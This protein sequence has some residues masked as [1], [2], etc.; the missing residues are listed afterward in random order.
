MYPYSE[1]YDI[2]IKNDGN[3]IFLDLIIQYITK[4]TYDV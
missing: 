4:G 2:L 3:L 1:L